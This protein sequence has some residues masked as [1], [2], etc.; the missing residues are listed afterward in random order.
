M[1]ACRNGFPSVKQQRDT[2]SKRILPSSLRTESALDVP[3]GLSDP[4]ISPELAQLS[5]EQMGKREA[6]CSSMCSAVT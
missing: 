2:P 4:L 1:H 6:K 3:A 5:C